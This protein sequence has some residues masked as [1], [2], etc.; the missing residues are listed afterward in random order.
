MLSLPIII[1][2][3]SSTPTTVCQIVP[4]F[5]LLRV[6]RPQ[7][8]LHDQISANTSI[9]DKSLSDVNK[10]HTQEY[11]NPSIKKGENRSIYKITK[12]LENTSSGRTVYSPSISPIIKLL[13]D[14]RHQVDLATTY[15][16]T[17][18]REIK[19]NKFT[20]NSR[21]VE[22]YKKGKTKSSTTMTVSAGFLGRLHGNIHA[23]DSPRNKRKYK[24]TPN[25]VTGKSFTGSYEVSASKV[26]EVDIPTQATTTT[27]TPSSFPTRQQSPIT[28][29]T[30]LFASPNLTLG[31]GGC[32]HSTP[33][34]SREKLV[35]SSSYGMPTSI[36]LGVLIRSRQSCPCAGDQCRVTPSAR[37]MVDL[38]IADIRKYGI[39]SGIIEEDG[40][41]E[42]HQSEGD[43]G[44]DNIDNGGCRGEGNKVEKEGEVSA[45][46]GI[47]EGVNGR[48]GGGGEINVSE[49]NLR[50]GI[51]IYYEVVDT[52]ITA[53]QGISSLS[54]LWARHVYGISGNKIDVFI[55]F[56]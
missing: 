53:P 8:S 35:K 7:I 31:V 52:G 19:S 55:G 54:E 9:F 29:D 34:R 37:G 26:G 21:K 10:P 15:H 16:I 44:G 24:T 12:P 4:L 46:K 6:T 42:D 41:G 5:Q 33:S 20:S 32:S 56:K 47:R 38:A 18:N 3:T 43:G 23:S 39:L 1:I 49:G 17:R 14:H 27:P 28:I 45:S 48:G 22:T 2:L 50:K 13:I 25:D 36:T 51:E 40:C 30:P 11:N